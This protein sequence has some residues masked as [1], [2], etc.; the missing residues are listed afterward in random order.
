MQNL[1]VVEFLFIQ[2]HCDIKQKHWIL[3]FITGFIVFGIVSQID[4]TE[5]IDLNGY[6]VNCPC[7]E[8]FVNQSFDFLRSFDFVKALNLTFILPPW[9]EYCLGEL[10]FIQVPFARYS[11]VNRLRELHCVITM[12][13][14]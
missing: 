13:S 8:R 4:L 3:Q 10:K 6:L 5:Q 12:L 7:M 9:I 11:Q 2:R 14:L 1:L